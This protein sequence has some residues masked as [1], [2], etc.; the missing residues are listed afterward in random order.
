M[1][2]MADPPAGLIAR[3]GE[4]EIVIEC[5]GRFSIRLPEARAV[6]SAFLVIDIYALDNAVHPEGHIGWWRY[7][8][9]ESP[10][11]LTGFLSRDL[12]GRIAPEINGAAPADE[13][14]NPLAP[15]VRRME[16]I[17]VLR[18]SITNAILSKDRVPVLS[19]VEELMEFRA[20]TVRELQNP[21]YRRPAHKLSACRKVHIVSKSMFE[22]DAVG[23]LC[24]QLY[25]MLFQAGLQARLFADDFDLAMND[26]INQRFLLSDS[27]G[28]EDSI[29]YFFSIFDER[30]EDVISLACGCRIA[31]YHGITPPQLLQVFDPEVAAQSGKAI[32]QLPLLRSFDR[33][34]ANSRASAD[35]L[36]AA[37]S[38][39][40]LPASTEIAVI[41]PKILS[42][43]ELQVTST[44]R[45]LKADG[46]PNLLFV[47]R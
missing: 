41:A 38:D 19:T 6:A 43:A 16:L 9:A 36:S 4:T 29:V 22:R 27:V 44:S 18:S 13:W 31:Y 26:V 32:R 33:L 10:Q 5:G 30:L 15:D 14:R 24:F 23:N 3:I 17:V 1:G 40:G 34:A 11:C 7:E 35:E 21:R 28:A 45:E 12:D 47:G 20:R 39:A 46:K 37:F 25:K 8:I 2:R 42:E